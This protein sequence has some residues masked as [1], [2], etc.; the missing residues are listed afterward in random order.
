MDLTKEGYPGRNYQTGRFLKGHVP[1]NAGKPWSEW[2]DGRKAKRVRR[3]AISNLKPRMD[4]A[5]WNKKPVVA[6]TEDGRHFY[7]ESA[8]QAGRTL[9]ISAR[10]INSC[11]LGKR[12]RC[13]G[14]RWF[15][16]TDPAWTK[17]IR[18]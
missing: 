4:L 13:G 18:K 3:I 17:L 5:G 14:F 12:K 9:G 11:C 1:H 10:N 15:Y 7:C 8:A 6:V 2:M 16:Y